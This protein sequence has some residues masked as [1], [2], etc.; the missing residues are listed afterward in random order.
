ML[1]NSQP[2]VQ[3]I[4]EGHYGGCNDINGTTVSKFHIPYASSVGSSTWELGEIVTAGIVRAGD[5]IRLPTSVNPSQIY[6]V[7][8]ITNTTL[9]VDTTLSPFPVT[10]INAATLMLEVNVV[11]SLTV[12]F[13]VDTVQQ[14]EDSYTYGVFFTGPHLGNVPLM[15]LEMCPSTSFNQYGGL[16]YGAK[17]T[18]LQAGGSAEVQVL[19]TQSRGYLS[20]S[21]GGYFKLVYGGYTL[22]KPSAI[23]G[24]NGFPWGVTAAALQTAMSLS[25]GPTVV[26]TRSGQGSLEE[27]QGYSYSIQFSDYST[28][29]F[30]G[31]AGDILQ[32]AVLTDQQVTDPSFFPGNYSEPAVTFSTM[33]DLSVTGKYT[34]SIDAQFT[35]TIVNT[36][37]NST[38]VDSFVWQ[39]HANTTS[40]IIPVTV[41]KQYYLQHGIYVSFAHARGHQVGDSWR[42]TA[43]RCQSPLPPDTTIALT[44]LISGTPV[45]GQVT[46]KPG[47]RS[48]AFTTVDVLKVP[49]VY[50][51]T[52]Q[53]IE[54]WKLVTN[55]PS[56]VLQPSLYYR[57]SFNFTFSG[58]KNE[59]TMCVPWDAP[60]YVVEEAISSM[61]GFC[62]SPVG[63]V[64][65]TRHVDNINNPGGYVYYIYFVN[66]KFGPFFDR[67]VDYQILLLNESGCQSWTPPK[68]VLNVQKLVDG[69]AYLPFTQALIPLGNPLAPSLP[70]TFRS[71]S[72][73]SVPIY[74]INGN[75]WSFTF[76]TNL[77][78]IAT[79]DSRI[80]IH[81]MT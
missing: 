4:D 17:V 18:P 41:G 22:I 67:N 72:V 5:R 46:V 3:V 26:V 44:T 75:Y 51:V 50:A 61:V 35:V 64:T 29:A 53:P 13:S 12:Q 69:S 80:Y 49:P 78:K 23:A 36:T 65:V 8:D 25:L 58:S 14:G 6:R 76:N 15:V 47:Y 21:G 1:G 52:M 7:L 57:F 59:S 42:F 2:F 48:T 73:S 34:G 37:H 20:P 11:D 56:S 81:R 31:A 32:L 71:V 16:R 54:T 60:D 62:S 68:S 77:G 79:I 43:V 55:D 39:I 33:N 27:M 74:K 45:T 38:H 9:T 66:P 70:A 24:T 30:V 28:S 10:P 63:C 19:T 40:P